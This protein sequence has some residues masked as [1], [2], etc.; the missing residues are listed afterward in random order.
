MTPT[1][2]QVV[3]AMMVAALG[4]DLNRLSWVCLHVADRH[5]E[6]SLGRRRLQDAAAALEWTGRLLAILDASESDGG[7]RGCR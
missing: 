7:L 3:D 1:P 6:D 5:D 2:D 4:G